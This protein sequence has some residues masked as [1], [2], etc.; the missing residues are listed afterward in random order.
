MRRCVARAWL[1]A[2][3]VAGSALLGACG[4]AA[5][6]AA[7]DVTQAEAAKADAAPAFTGN[8][9]WWN[10]AEPGTGFFFEAQ[11]ATGVVTFYMYEDNGRPVWYTAAGPLTAVA[12]GGSKYQFSGTLQRYAGG[13][14][15]GS[16]VRKLPTSSSDA[17]TVTLAFDGFQAQGSVAGRALKAQKYFQSGG[18]ALGQ[19]ETGAYWNSLENGRGYAMEVNNNTVV[20]GVFHYDDSGQPVWN[21]STI[22][23]AGRAGTGDFTAFRGGQT[24]AGAYKAPTGSSSQGRLGIDFPSACSGQ[25]TFGDLPPIAIKRFPFG[26]LPPGSECRA[27]GGSGTSDLAAPFVG[28]WVGCVGFSQ[29]LSRRERWELAKTQEGAGS[30]LYR[31]IVTQHN[32]LDCTGAA[33]PVSDASGRFAFDTSGTP[34]I[35]SVVMHRVVDTTDSRVKYLIGVQADGA[36]RIGDQ[37]TNLDAAGYA[38]RLSLLVLNK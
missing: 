1:A 8:G 18:P 6:P 22:P 19:P 29:T 37:S 2:F 34:I 35:D 30:L 26:S 9:I 16:L 12:G 24:L 25:L 5:G 4:G 20:L 33:T 17:G 13:Q 15:L 3:A 11:G 28:N 32:S 23:L 7:P 21:L 31:I 38:T 27:L 14:P 10:P 36:L